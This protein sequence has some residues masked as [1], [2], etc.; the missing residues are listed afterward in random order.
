M[1]LAVFPKP[2]PRSTAYSPR[3][4]AWT[5][6]DPAKLAEMLGLPVEFVDQA[7]EKTGFNKAVRIRE[8]VI[9]WKENLRSE[10]RA[11][12]SS[13]KLIES[14]R[15]RIRARLSAVQEQLA[16]TRN[17][18]RIPREAPAHLRDAPAQKVVS[19]AGGPQ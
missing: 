2:L 4:A 7:L 6:Y 3:S 8:E 14:E 9:R 5:L 19:E 12:L 16:S 15:R 1:N 11:L 10:E 13:I 18:L 17:I